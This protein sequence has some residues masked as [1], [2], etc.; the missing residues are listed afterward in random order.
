MKRILIAIT[1]LAYLALGCTTTK[2]PSI[3][4]G[5]LVSALESKHRNAVYIAL[6]TLDK[7][8]YGVPEIEYKKPYSQAQPKL[9]KLV[10]MLEQLPEDKLAELNKSFKYQRSIYSP[11]YGPENIAGWIN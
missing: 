5:E 1:L 10:Q 11:I 9:R 2:P 7:N 8:K 3:A 6:W 4:K